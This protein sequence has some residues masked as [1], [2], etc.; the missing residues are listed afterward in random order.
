M[1]KKVI[2]GTALLASASFATFSN[3]PV[4]AAMSGDAKIVAD[5]IVHDKWKGLDLSAKARFVPVQNLELYL[6]LPFR[7]ISRYDGENDHKTGMENLTTG[8]RYQVAPMFAAFLDVTFPTGKDKISDD[9]FNFYF[10]GQFSKDFGAVGLGTEAG[11]SITTEGDD[12]KKGPMSLILNA[13]LDP[14]VSQVVSP[15]FGIT[16]DILLNDEKTRGKKSAETSGDVGVA[17]YV[18][19]NFKVNQLLSFDACVTFGLGDDDYLIYTSG[20]K[21]MTVTWEGSVNFSF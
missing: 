15:Y 18:G 13:E 12:R 2:V 3:F 7:P 14:N 11:L 5:F 17:P 6:K 8:V 4:P 9:G 1:L 20:N 21:K 16:F 19:A 10:G